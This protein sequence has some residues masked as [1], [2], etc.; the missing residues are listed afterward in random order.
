MTLR[1]RIISAVAGVAAVLAT[2]AVA[3]SV[4]TYSAARPEATSGTVGM[5]PADSTP[6]QA[7]RNFACG[8][9]SQ[10]VCEKVETWFP[11]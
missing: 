10:A 7:G 2:V 9:P 6:F 1:M 4:H 3:R 8:L 11:E 5:A